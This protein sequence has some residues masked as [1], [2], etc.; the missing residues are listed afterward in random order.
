MERILLLSGDDED[1]I[2]ALEY[3]KCG[4][5]DWSNRNKACLD[6]LKN[7]PQYYVDKEEG[8]L[9][10]HGGPLDPEKIAPPG[11]WRLR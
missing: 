1:S 11:P 9:A 10:V 4:G 2:R 6:F 3:L 5:P 8:F 7:L